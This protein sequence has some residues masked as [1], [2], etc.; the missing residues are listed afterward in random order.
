MKRPIMV[1]IKGSYLKLYSL[2]VSD[3][4]FRAGCLLLF[5]ER[6]LRRNSR[7]QRRMWREVSSFGLAR[8]EGL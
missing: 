3:L 4:G 5:G 7:H 1:P 2:S 8:G 6:E